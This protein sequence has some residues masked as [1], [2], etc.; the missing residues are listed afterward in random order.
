[1][2]SHL[3][4]RK[5]LVD[6]TNLSAKGRRAVHLFVIFWPVASANG[7]PYRFDIN[8]TTLASLSGG[9]ADTGLPPYRLFG[10][11]RFA[12]A[13]MVL[14]QHCLLL[15]PDPAKETFYWLELGAVAVTVFFALSGFVVAE[16]VT[17][18]YAGH[19]ARFLANRLLRLFPL[20]GAVLALTIGLDS[21][22]YAGGRLVPLDGALHGPPWQA[23]VILSGLLDIVPGLPAHR[24][25]ATAFSFIPFAWTL[26]IELLFYLGAAFIC[27]LPVRYRSA[28]AMVGLS[29]A[30][31]GLFLSQHGHLPGQMLCIPIFAF[32]IC[33]YRAP[34][35]A[36]AW[37]TINLFGLAICSALAFTY[38]GQRGH[39]VLAFQ[40]PLLGLLFAMLL[41]LARMPVRRSALMAWDKR[42]GALSYPIYIGHGVILTALRSLTPDR[43][44]LLYATGA[45]AAILLAVILDAAID[46]PMRSIRTRVRGASI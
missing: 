19:P 13:V 21:A 40:L 45:L 10:A 24:P 8:M 38:W 16:A 3:R 18:F 7:G 14:L 25:G 12:L 43:S 27:W 42:L 17:R 37:H 1:M 22:L 35:N 6:K 31:F 29:Y 32:G 11:F 5:L 15:L 44:W 41:V 34:R 36:S 9:R 2:N 46:R 33:A 20:Y 39:P 4:L 28:P 23:G 30:L 26:R